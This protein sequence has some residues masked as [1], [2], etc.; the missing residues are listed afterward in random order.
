MTYDAA[1]ASLLMNPVPEVAGLRT[2]L[3]LNASALSLPSDNATSGLLV[4]L[5]PAPALLLSLGAP[6]LVHMQQ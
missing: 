1:S 6:S 4:G 3:L 2:G 5:H